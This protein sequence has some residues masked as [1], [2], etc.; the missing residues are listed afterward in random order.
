MSRASCLV[1]LLAAIISWQS[2]EIDT[3]LRHWDPGK[4]GIDPTISSS[5]VW[6]T[7]RNSLIPLALERVRA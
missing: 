1:L 3:V 4:E 7:S 2:R 6:K 5:T